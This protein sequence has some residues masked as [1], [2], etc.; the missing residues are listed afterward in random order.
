VGAVSIVLA[1]GCGLAPDGTGPSDAGTGAVDATNDRTADVLVQLEGA[2]TDAPTLD[3]PALAD[4]RRMDAE[5]G[6]DAADDARDGATADGPTVPDGASPDAG[7]CAPACGVGSACASPGDCLSNVC[8]G[9]HCQ[10]GGTGLPCAYNSANCLSNN[11]VGLSDTCAAGGAG[12]GCNTP[13]DCL[14]NACMG[15]HCQLGGTGLPC[16]YNSANCLSD[17]CVGLSDTCAAGGAGDGCNTPGDC[18]SN[19]C[20]G[21]K[22]ELGAPGSACAYNSA[23]C[24]SN[25]CTIIDQCNPGADGTACRANTDCGSQVCTMGHCAPPS[26]VT[27]TAK[28]APG[29]PCGSSSDCTDGTC[30]PNFQCN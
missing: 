18:L 27:P 25:D 16:A 26:C 7:A 15:N 19:A 22:C 21:N 3:A 4:A 23:N 5:G 2:T 6:D 20:T 11:C 8:M 17:N 10:L 1:A 24:L 29:G 28:C 9:N 13:G 14:S 30:Y 12:N